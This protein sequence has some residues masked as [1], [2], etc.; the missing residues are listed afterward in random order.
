M[1]RTFYFLAGLMA[2]ALLAAQPAGSAFDEAD[3]DGD[4]VISREEFRAAREA[5]GGPGGRGRRLPR[6]LIERFDEDGDGRLSEAEREAAR[7]AFQERRQEI[8][9]RFDEDGD[10]E[11]NSDER[12]IARETLREEKLLE[13]FDAN[14]DGV[15]SP[16]EQAR[17][18]QARAKWKE[19]RGSLRRRAR[20]RGLN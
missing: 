18:D 13:L 15:L 9:E 11:L 16:E 3:T 5:I 6:K 12:G 1:K 7:A 10:G 20:G 14:G 2:P 19:T 4:G 17:A 8:I